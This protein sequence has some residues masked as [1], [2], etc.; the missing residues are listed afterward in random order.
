MLSVGYE[1]GLGIL[2]VEVDTLAPTTTR[3]IVVRST[4]IEYDTDSRGEFVGS[5]HE[6][7]PFFL[8]VFDCGEE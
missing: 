2:F 8:H 1:S 3:R 4:G 5:Y 6:D 7:G